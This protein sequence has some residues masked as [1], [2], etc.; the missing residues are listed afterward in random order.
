MIFPPHKKQYK[1]INI[2]E[3]NTNMT[4]TFKRII[5]LVIATIM[6]AAIGTSV[7]AAGSYEISIKKPAGDKAKHT[8]TAYQIFAGTVHEDPTTNEKTLLVSGWGYDVN[9]GDAL[10]EDLKTN[11]KTSGVFSSCTSVSD[12]AGALAEN[13]DS[14]AAFADVA[15]GHLKTAAHNASVSVGPTEDEAVAKLTVDEEGY[16]LITDEIDQS[17]DNNGAISKYMLNV[18]DIHTDSVV[19]NAK[20]DLPSIDKKIVETSGEV[21]ANTA[22]VGE[23]ITFKLTSSV[24]DTTYYEK[25]FFVV[26][27][28]LSEG[29]TFK[30]GS[31]KVKIGDDADD[32]DSSKYTVTTS[33]DDGKTVLK[34]VFDDFKNNLGSRTG[35]AIT[36]TYVASL[37]ENADRTT[38][39]NTNTVNLTYSNDPNFDYTGTNEPGDNE[40]KGVTPDKVTIT[41]TTDF[42]IVKI[43]SKTEKRLPGAGF[44]LKLLGDAA[45]KVI[46]ET[47][48]FAQAT[49]SEAAGTTYYYKL[50]N[51]SYTETAP[52]ALGG[53]GTDSNYADTANSYVK[54]V[55]RTIETKNTEK[56]VTAM[57][58][59]Q[60]YL[61]FAGLD[62]GTYTLVESTVPTGYTDPKTTYTITIDVDLSSGTPVWSYEVSDG[63]TSVNTNEIIVEN[64]MNTLPQTGG[65]GTTVFYIVGSILVAAGV[66]LL[67]TKKRLEKAE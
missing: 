22:S 38:T 34:I 54:T 24:P 20:E 11:T 19:I 42:S 18:V 27:D 53:S 23:E 3:R 26:N 48:S 6:M 47:E 1:K 14:A 28:T 25:Y 60:G 32:Y 64:T 45:E 44:T 43:D 39:G 12:V 46:V 8:Y 36:I 16:Y 33:D 31:V 37:N 56:E 35:D 67:I 55:T 30:D 21:T 15:S 50:N 4:K 5:S 63:T 2:K 41:Y 66:V 62:A 57:V 13:P 7:F 51:G 65:M 52:A 9:D 59:D 10:L 40:P 29:L 49:G 58:D 17:G 61:C